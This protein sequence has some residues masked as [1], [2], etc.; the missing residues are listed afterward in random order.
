MFHEKLRMFFVFM[1]SFPPTFLVILTFFSKLFLDTENDML[2]MKSGN[3]MPR[4]MPCLKSSVGY[5]GIPDHFVPQ[6]SRFVVT[7]FILKCPY[8]TNNFILCF[9]LNKARNRYEL[10]G[11]SVK[12]DESTYRT[13]ANPSSLIV[14]S[15]IEQ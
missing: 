14:D 15:V 7:F 10:D 6:N 3:S 12:F 8:Y 1:N 5:R 9:I 2:H 4:M 13:A 11:N